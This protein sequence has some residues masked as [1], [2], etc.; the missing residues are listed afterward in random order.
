MSQ[1]YPQPSPFYPPE[2]NPE[3][4]YYDEVEYEIEEGDYTRSGD[5]LVQRIL[6][7]FAGG[8]LVFLCMSCCGLLGIGLWWLDPGNSLSSTPIPGSDIGLSFDDPAFPDE[9]VVNDQK[10]KLTILE[11][12]RNAALPTVPTVEGREL[13]VTTIEL[14]NLGEEDLSFNER[15]FVL[16]NRFEEAYAPTPGVIDGALG[17]GS[18]PVGTGLEGRLVF[19]VIAGELDLILVWDSGPDSEPRYIWLE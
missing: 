12:N 4:D 5:T 6:I 16:L 8:C 9:S 1:Y 13:I 7:F 11:V 15:D 14:V 10:I 17:R 19:E 3:E 18:L 2:Q